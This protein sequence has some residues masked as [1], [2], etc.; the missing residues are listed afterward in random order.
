MLLTLSLASAT[1][2]V[3]E[4]SV[5]FAIPDAEAS[6]VTHAGTGPWTTDVTLDFTVE[7]IIV[8]GVLRSN[9]PDTVAEEVEVTVTMETGDDESLRMPD[10]GTVEVAEVL[11]ARFAVTPGSPV[12]TPV[13]VEVYDDYDDGTGADAA[14]DVLYV[15]LADVTVVDGGGDL[16]T[17][18]AAS[19][20]TVQGQIH[21]MGKD[22]WTFTIP[23]DVDEYG[24]MLRIELA[25]YLGYVDTEIALYDAGGNHIADADEN[26]LLWYDQLSFAPTDLFDAGAPGEHGS[27]LPAGTYTAVV[28]MFSTD[29]GATLTTITPGEETQGGDYTLTLQYSEFDPTDCT[30][31]ADEGLCT[32][33]NHGAAV[34]NLVAGEV[35]YAEGSS[36]A[37]LRPST[38][39]ADIQDLSDDLAG[40]GDVYF[41]LGGSILGNRLSGLDDGAYIIDAGFRSG[42]VSGEVLFPEGG[43]T[44][45]FLGAVYG[46]YTSRRFITDINGETTAMVAGTWVRTYGRKGSWVGVVAEC[47]SGMP[48][49]VE[50]WFGKSIV[51]WP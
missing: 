16:G 17:L 1:T 37:R 4:D 26:G 14:F 35:R 3:I 32:M 29:F 25:P 2:L 43:E 12:E 47:T 34:S 40:C 11:E 50:S 36:N 49:P 18:A 8:E 41:P 30:G 6:D 48:T 44:A 20:T 42:S 27:T 24:D 15:T 7:Q 51:G 19:T 23:E 21:G 38:L 13:T 31:T 33:A 46:G 39:Y 28:T 45:A 22:V 9:L 10:F 5:T